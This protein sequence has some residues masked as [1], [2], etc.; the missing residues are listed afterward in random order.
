[1]KLGTDLRMDNSLV[2]ELDSFLIASEKRRIALCKRR[3]P[4]KPFVIVVYIQRRVQGTNGY[5][6]N[7]IV[8][9]YSE[10]YTEEVARID[11]EKRRPQMRDASEEVFEMPMQ[12]G[13]RLV[14]EVMEEKLN[15]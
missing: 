3:N 9:S 11:F 10:Y 1:M 4:V 6:V 8:L 14:Q 13:K 7:W 12:K 15:V 2:E 5:A